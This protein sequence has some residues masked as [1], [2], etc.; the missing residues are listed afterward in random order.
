MISHVELV[1][2]LYFLTTSGEIWSWRQAEKCDLHIHKKQPHKVGKFATCKFYLLLSLFS[3]SSWRPVLQLP[4][5]EKA[6]VAVR[7]CPVL[8][9]L[10]PN[11]TSESESEPPLFKWG[12]MSGAKMQGTVVKEIVF[13]LFTQSAVSHGICSGKSR[14]CSPV[15]HTTPCSLRVCLQYSLRWD[16]WPHMVHVYNWLGSAYI[17]WH[18]N[19]VY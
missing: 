12:L 3:H 1:L 2:L 8:F 11:L 5:P 16:H 18:H 7:C 19:D 9:E 14:F 6:T 10:L 13:F 15:R 4:G 17:T